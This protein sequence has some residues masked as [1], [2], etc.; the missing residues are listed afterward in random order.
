MIPT[1]TAGQIITEYFQYIVIFGGMEVP[2]D[3]QT[4]KQ[5]SLQDLK[6]IAYSKTSL[7][8]LDTESE[9][10]YRVL[11]LDTTILDWPVDF[12]YRQFMNALTIPNKGMIAYI[13]GNRTVEDPKSSQNNLLMLNIERVV[14]HIDYQRRENPRQHVFSLKANEIWTKPSMSSDNEKISLFKHTSV[15]LP[16]LNNV[17]ILGGLKKES[18]IEKPVFNQDLFVLNLNDNSINLV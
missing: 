4:N 13:G 2:I 6:S 8:I 18:T 9:N 12:D 10:W 5:K 17:L 11:P 14:Q 7:Y 1:L 15:L 16:D 3:P